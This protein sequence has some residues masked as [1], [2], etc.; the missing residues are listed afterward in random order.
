MPIV[1]TCALTSGDRQMSS[2]D[3]KTSMTP[4]TP[5]QKA[6]RLASENR[7]LH[8]KKASTKIGFRQTGCVVKRKEEPEPSKDQIKH[9]EALVKYDAMM[10]VGTHLA[11]Q[12]RAKKL[13]AALKSAISNEFDEVRTMGLSGNLTTFKQCDYVRILAA[14]KAAIGGAS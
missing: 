5:K 3:R 6:R 10:R 4:E 7:K 1:G 8:E 14:C 13:A 9:L 2:I 11:L 12:Q